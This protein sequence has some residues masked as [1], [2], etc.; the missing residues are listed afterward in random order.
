MNI[1][2]TFI[3]ELCNY[4]NADGSLFEVLFFSAHPDDEIVG[5]GAVLKN[6][7]NRVQVIT[8][9]NGSPRNLKDAMSAGYSSRQAYAEAR[10]AEQQIALSYAEITS[11]QC[12]YFDVNDQESSLNI[13]GIAL[14]I[15]DLLEKKKP[16]IIITHAFEGG[17]P[18]HDTVAFAVWAASL[19]LKRR[20]KF[21]PQIYEYASYHGNGGNEMVQFEFIPYTSS[22]VYSYELSPDETEFKQQLVKCFPTQS[23]MLSQFPLTTERFRKVPVYN[24][25]YPPHRGVLLYEFYDWGMSAKR[26]LQLAGEAMR[27]LGV[28]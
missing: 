16:C 28:N 4:R 23:K 17:H 27:L 8:V 24:F 26:W 2:N 18:D 21:V 1:P 12:E 20:G 15:I 22:H 7:K 25:F 5:A 9:T 14:R 3:E 6:L 11:A 13:A 19:V 10:K